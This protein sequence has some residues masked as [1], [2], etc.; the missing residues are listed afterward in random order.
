MR[1]APLGRINVRIRVFC[2][3]L[4][5]QLIENNSIKQKGKRITRKSS[6][7]FARIEVRYFV[8]SQ[9]PNKLEVFLEEEVC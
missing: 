8:H 6:N 9:I 4:A 5:Y 7:I 3:H 1:E 2:N